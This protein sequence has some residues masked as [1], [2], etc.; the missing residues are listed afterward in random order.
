MKKIADLHIPQKGEMRMAVGGEDRRSGLA[1][2][3]GAL[4]PALAVPKM[5]SQREVVTPK[6]HP[7]WD[8]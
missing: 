1:K 5:W 2:S 7:S 8:A 6:F 3:Q 4:P